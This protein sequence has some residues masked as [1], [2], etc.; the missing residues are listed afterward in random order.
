MPKSIELSIVLTAHR[1]GIVS[2]ATG[3]SASAALAAFKRDVGKPVEKILVLDRA[4]DLTGSILE[5][6]FK[7]DRVIKSDA[8]DP[9]QAR[10]RGVEAAKGKY[11]CFLDGDD[12]W[13]VNWLVEAH[14][15][16]EK[17]PDAVAHSQC[18]IV[19]GG[20]NNIWWHIDS[21][22]ALY[23]PKYLEWANYWD[24]MSFARTQ[25]YRDFPFRRNDLDI[26]FAHEDWHWNCSTI[27][28]GIAHKPA[29]NTIHFKRRRRGSVS[30]R[31][32]E[33]AGT[34]W[35]QSVPLVEPAGNG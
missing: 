5:E 12:L 31:A 2:G 27:A 26:G 35:P 6:T 28:A 10:N 9:G 25:I 23:D 8:G 32:Q 30:A 17:R 1:E 34:V 19:F 20:D 29:P 18:N 16:V 4:D 24:A 14:R 15:L 3:R 13:S 11:L 22:G 33:R 21:E 7:P